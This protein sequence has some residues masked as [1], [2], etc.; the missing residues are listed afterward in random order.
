MRGFDLFVEVLI[1]IGA[2]NWGLVG[3]F[4]YNLV[5][6]IF[7]EFA[8]VIYAVVGLAGLYEIVAWRPLHM[9][10]APRQPAGGRV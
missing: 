5:G 1:L 7:G 9:R 8:R 6:A 4:D 10:L 3:F 2:L